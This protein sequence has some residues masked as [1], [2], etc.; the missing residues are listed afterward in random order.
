MLHVFYISC[1]F[2]SLFIHVSF[3]AVYPGHLLIPYAC[4]DFI[5]GLDLL[6]SIRYPVPLLNN[7]QE[8]WK[9]LVWQRRTFHNFTYL[10]FLFKAFS[11]IFLLSLYQLLTYL[12]D[13][14]ILKIAYLSIFLAASVHSVFKAVELCLIVN[15][16]ASSSQL[17]C[18]LS[19]IFYT[20]KLDGYILEPIPISLAKLA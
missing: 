16:A 5:S 11:S 14:Y 19:L 3:L 15:S 7:D 10:S 13:E 9:M 4:I 20:I 2:D 8:L 6:F 18:R 12:F 1:I 17:T